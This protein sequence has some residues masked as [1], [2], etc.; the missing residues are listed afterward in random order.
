MDTTDIEFFDAY[1]RLDRLCADVLRS[2]NGV[3]EYIRQMEAEPQGR[4]KVPGWTADYQALKHI[5]WVRNRIAHD[6]SDA[7]S[8][9]DDIEFAEEF[10]DRI[11]HQTD[12]FAQLR[13]ATQ[14][15]QQTQPRT[16]P[17]P[18][19]TPAPASN[20]PQSNNTPVLFMVA[21]LMVLIVMLLLWFANILR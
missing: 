19:T 9:E 1:R 13:K 10:Y 20:Y 14:K 18:T 16:T 7:I 6:A 8:T 21:I 2:H 12:P 3:G 15:P 11:L 5:R 4:H 17:A